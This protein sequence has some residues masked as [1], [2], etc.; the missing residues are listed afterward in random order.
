MT[1]TLCIILC[2]TEQNPRFSK[3]RAKKRGETTTLPLLPPPDILLNI[4]NGA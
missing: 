3:N 4:N 2:K 1:C